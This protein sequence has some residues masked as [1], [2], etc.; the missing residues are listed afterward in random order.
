MALPQ[1]PSP[2]TTQAV[3][4]A[5]YLRRQGLPIS[6]AQTL[7]FVHSLAWI[8]V[9][10]W[11]TV[12]DASRTVFVRRQEE[13]AAFE[14]AFERFWTNAVLDP[15]NAA[16]WQTCATSRYGRSTWWRLSTLPTRLRTRQPHPSLQ[17]RR[18][19]AP[20]PDFGAL[21]VDESVAIQS[22][23]SIVAKRLPMRRSRRL[24][25]AR[26]GRQLDL[27]STLRA[28]LRTG[29]DPPPPRPPQAPGQAAPARHHLRC[30]W[31][32]GTLCPN[33]TPVRLRSGQ[34]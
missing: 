25:L 4:F 6:P 14:A 28:S 9:A 5:R 33:P 29:G 27:R 3:R 12:R 23:M 13:I 32:D 2:I 16:P 7:D 21:T 34:L 24:R 17:H 1:I 10:D 26:H 11:P 15:R 8:D 19:P 30:Q 31:L 22:A 18:T 20:A